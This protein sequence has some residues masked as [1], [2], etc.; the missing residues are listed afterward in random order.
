MYYFLSVIGILLLIAIIITR[1]IVN[2]KRKAEEAKIAL[3]NTLLRKVGYC[4]RL[5]DSLTVS[6]DNDMIAAINTVALKAYKEIRDNSLSNVNKRINELEDKICVLKNTKSESTIIMIPQEESLRNAAS[7]DLF[8]LNKFFKAH[9]K[10]H[11]GLAT[12]FSAELHKI[13]N[14]LLGAKINDALSAGNFAIKNNI[15]G[16]AKHRFEFVIQ[17]LDQNQHHKTLFMEH[18]ERAAE[19]LQ[20]VKESMA[21]DEHIKE[22]YR[23]RGGIEKSISNDGLDRVTEIHKVKLPA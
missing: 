8:R 14:T 5:I 19:R 20:Y 2:E 7:Q 6:I 18:Y 10:A 1:T 23:I 15:L 12:L 16:T 11:P 13:E 4:E 22:Q 17:I 9:I 21:K 3:K